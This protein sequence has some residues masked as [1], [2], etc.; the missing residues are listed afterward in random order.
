MTKKRCK[1][2]R[3]TV[4]R[5]TRLSCTHRHNADGNNTLFFAIVVFGVY[6]VL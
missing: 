1:G 5:I 2:L 4:E 3:K 6:N